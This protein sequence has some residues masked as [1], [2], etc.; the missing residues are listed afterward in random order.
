[1]GISYPSIPVLTNGQRGLLV[2]PPS[3]N[4]GSDG[5]EAGQLVPSRIYVFEDDLSLVELAQTADG[6]DDAWANQGTTEALGPTGLVVVSNDGSSL[7]LGV[8]GD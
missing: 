2:Y 5:L 7:W 8:P 6:P 1:M 4:S 3:L